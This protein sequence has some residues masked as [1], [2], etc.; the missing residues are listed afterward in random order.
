MYHQ[1]LH[2]GQRPRINPCPRHEHPGPSPGALD[3]SRVFIILVPDQETQCPRHGYPGCSP[4]AL[5]ISRVFKCLVPDQD[6]HAPGMVTL[7][8]VQGP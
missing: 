1:V 7:D 6:F 5:D 2:Q 3:I 8:P 4:G